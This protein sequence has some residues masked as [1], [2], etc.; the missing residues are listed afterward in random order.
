MIEDKNILLIAPDFFDY[1]KIIKNH[2]E[3]YKNTVDVILS[4]E[5]ENLGLRLVERYGNKKI[6]NYCEN[7]YYIKRANS[8]NKNFDYIFVIKGDTLNEI[9]LQELK[10]NFPKCQFIMY[11]WDPIEQFPSV[12][13][14][15]KYFD[16]VFTFEKEDAEKYGWSYR[17][18]FFENVLCEE[19]T[20]K[21]IDLVYICTMKYNRIKLYKKIVEYAEKN[22]LKLFSYIYVD[23]LTYLKR[24]WLQHDML[25]SKID[26]DSV[27]FKPLNQAEVNMIYDRAKIIVDYTNPQ[28]NGL[29]IRTIE[30]IG[31]KCKLIT[32]N[33][34]I[35]NNNILEHENIYIYDENNFEITDD[36][37]NSKYKEV[38][39]LV[40][41]FYSVDGWLSSIF[42]NINSEWKK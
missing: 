13:N 3:K 14:I 5:S 27:H 18:L 32:N 23:K 33:N 11:Q 31:H 16:R 7:K 35:V 10:N 6:K 20:Q 25:Y 39:K 22:E 29:S 24:R 21:D 4:M 9:V 15:I 30:S 41:D 36:F 19:K 12:L 34:N 42:D 26:R 38:D 37:I 1:W 8:F 17:P 28:Q 40:Y 2:M